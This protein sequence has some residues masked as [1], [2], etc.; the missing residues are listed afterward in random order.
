MAVPILRKY[1]DVMKKLVTKVSSVLISALLLTLAAC[2]AQENPQQ[3]DTTENTQQN[4]SVHNIIKSDSL[5]VKKIDNLPEDFIMGCDISTVISE[6]N[7]GVRYYDYDGNEADLF[8]VLKASGVNYV[9]VRVWNDPKDENGNGYGG[10]NCDIETAC[11]I[12][13][14]AADAGLKLLVDFHYSDFWADPTKQMVPKAWEGMEIE[15]KKEAVYEY[16]KDCLNKLNEAGADIGMVQVGNETNGKMCGEKIWMNIYYLMDA[17]SRAVRE[18][19]PDAL[20]A[21]HF[22]NPE[23]VDRMLNYSSKLYY[24]KLDYDVFALSYYPYWHGSLENLTSVMKEISEKYGKKVMIAET[25]YAYTLENG[26]DQGNTIGDVINYE[27]HYPISVQGQSREIADVIEA[28]C[29]VGESGIG[30]FYWEPAWIPVPGES[31]EER[32]ELWEKY[33]SGWASSYS[34]AYDP[35]DAGLYYGGCAWENQALFDFEGK[36][37][38]SLKTFGLVY[39]GNTVDLVPDAIKDSEMIV[40]LGEK[41]VLP[42]TVSAIYNDGSEKDI[43]VEWESADLEAMTNGEPAAYTVNG[44]SD[45][46]PTVC[47]ISMVEANYCEN[48]SFEDAD[49]SMW[50]IENPDEKTTQIDYQQKAMDAVTGEYSLHF[51]GEKGTCFNAY[52]EIKNLSPGRYSLTASVQ[53]GF[54]G[55]DDSQNIY[56]YCNVNGTEY[57]AKGE[58]NGWVVWSNP[59]IDEIEIPENAEVTIGIHVEAGE[60]SWGTVDDFL[61]NPLK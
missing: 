45:G 46:M 58:M 60:Q 22:T 48:Y 30:V 35:D 14:R 28:V 12:G 15:E 23:T 17:G 47:R 5:Y 24:Y 10:G 44:T 37:L 20:V 57:M 38:E 2:S 56:I 53:G 49:R 31:W 33:G 51:W 6:E 32:N 18:M 40:R 39:T 42:E 36:P 59:K 26:D 50:I 21:V 55:S 9:R 43:P 25:S 52:Q 29:N 1:G 19:N 8:S 27:K 41:I 3:T 34:A 4:E 13:K 61:L 16:T 11:L 7:S 54:S